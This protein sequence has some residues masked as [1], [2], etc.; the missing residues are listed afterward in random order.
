[1]FTELEMLIL[2]QAFL[3]VPRVY[4]HCVGAETDSV[5]FGITVAWS[6]ELFHVFWFGRN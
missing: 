2:D 5:A 6:P 1:M 4:G 3:A